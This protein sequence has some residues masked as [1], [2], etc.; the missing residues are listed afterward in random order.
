M[1][2]E[3]FRERCLVTD[4]GC[5]V[6]LRAKNNMGYGV[7][8]RG[9]KNFYA[10]RYAWELQN[11]PIQPGLVICHRC[12]NPSCCNPNHMFVGSQAE[13][14]ADMVRKGRSAKGAQHSQA[15][16]A[17]HQVI[18]IRGLYAA[19]G[20]T[21]ADIAKQF[22]ISREAVGLIVRRQRWAHL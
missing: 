14:L 7:F 3:F 9:G 5:F 19:G 2:P 6:W 18:A 8:R 1:H 15:K 10:H 20:A 13:N 11:G 21:H 22:G 12:D 4:A 16:I 17:A